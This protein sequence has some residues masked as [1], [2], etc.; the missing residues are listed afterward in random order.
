MKLQRL[1]LKKDIQNLIEESEGG[2]KLKRTLT[3]THLV[4]LGL[5]AIIGTGIFV[6]TGQAAAEYA[7]PALTISF[8]IS[9]IACIFAGLCYAELAAMIPV[10]G[11]VYS[12]S[13][14]T[15]GE[16]IAW[17]IG[18]DLILEYTV[19]SITVSIGWSGY[20]VM[21]L[22]T[23]GIHL[24]AFLC[25]PPFNLPAAIIVL[26]ITTILVIG[27]RESSRFN[28]V[29][30]VIKLAVI[31]FFI[32]F[33][34]LFLRPENWSPFMPFGLTGVMTG[35][36]M[37]FFAYIGFDAISTTAEEAKNPQRDLPIGIIASLATCTLLY[38]AVAIVL[39]GIVPVET[40]ANNQHFLHAPVAYALSYIN[41]GWASGVISIGAIMG[42]TSVLLVMMMGQPRVFFAMS[43]D[44][45]LPKKISTVHK[46]FKTPYITTIMTGVIVAIIAMMIPIGTAAELANI[47]TLFA[48]AIVCAAVLILRRRKPDVKRV[49]KVPIIY[50]IA[51]LGVLTS[52][53]LMCSLPILTWIR[54]LIW[55]DIGLIIYYFYSR[56][57]S[58]LAEK[59]NFIANTSLK[60]FLNFFATIITCNGL[61][62]GIL[63]IFAKLGLTSVKG[64]EEISFT[65]DGFLI[66]CGFLTVLGI[67][68][69]L[70]SKFLKDGTG[71]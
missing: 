55:L 39:T 65:P 69:Y 66:L 33:G 48:F 60:H 59:H 29:M 36:A 62:L 15:I 41:Q 51:P 45:L 49:F 20:F 1:F 6:I 3:T 5:G 64:W 37:V 53:G 67:G 71:K 25:Q 56:K 7:G 4:A 12:Y 26:I 43:R 17:F 31:L 68:L 63:S 35:A 57:H 27:I 44:K 54:F 32:L 10:S 58:R 30:V 13:Y 50:L 14:A 21:L 8:V 42:I 47:G 11:S 40:V 46:K 61:I 18:W 19:V 34:A 28:N 22:K 52:V 23:I 9:A 70:I 16:F 2:N 38:I 24:P